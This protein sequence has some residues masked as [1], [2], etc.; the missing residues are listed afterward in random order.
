MSLDPALARRQVCD[1]ETIGRKTGLPRR[2]E[3]WFAADPDLTRIY[4][5][6]GGRDQAHWVQNT[7][8]N[9]AVRVAFGERWFAG[10]AR[11]VVPGPEDELARRLV[12]TKYEAWREGRPLSSWARTS[13]PVAIDLENPTG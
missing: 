8:R 13:L 5:L 3:I 10:W 9:A 12:A 7:R 11:E 4:V 6:S 2:I 1:L